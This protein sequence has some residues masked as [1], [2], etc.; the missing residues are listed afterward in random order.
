M[1]GL[2]ILLGKKLRLR[3]DFPLRVFIG[4]CGCDVVQWPL[5]AN[6]GV[7]PGDAP[8]ELRRPEICGFVKEFRCFTENQETVR[9][10]LRHPDLFVVLRG[11]YFAHP[12]A[13]CGRRLPDIHRNIKYFALRYAH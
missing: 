1:G 7:V 3:Q 11:K 2:A 6:G 8:L 4:Q 10:A 9:K 13:E 5:N 12:F